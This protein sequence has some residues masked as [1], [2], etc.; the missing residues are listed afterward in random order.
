MK[1]E[2][3]AMKKAKELSQSRKNG[4]A[5]FRKVLEETAI[6]LGMKNLRFDIEQECCELQ[7]HGIDKVRF[8]FA[9]NKQQQL[10]PIENTASGGELSRVMLCIKSIIAQNM[11]LPTIIFDEVDT[12]VSGEVAHKM[13]EMM[14]DISKKI[15]VIAIT[16][17]PQVAV[18]GVN[19]LKVFKADSEDATYTSMCELSKEERVEEIARMLS[20]REIDEAAINNARSLLGY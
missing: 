8:L 2:A 17:L 20:G 9:F 11:Q 10:M 7:A 4:G 1:V 12:G 3:D 13:G 18:K 5:A 6:P 16:H 19:H 14:S 15:Q